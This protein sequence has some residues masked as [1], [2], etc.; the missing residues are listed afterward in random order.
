MATIVFLLTTACTKKEA[1]APVKNSIETIKEGL[2]A[3][4]VIF[5]GDRS[6]LLSDSGPDGSKSFGRPEKIDLS[7]SYSVP[8]ISGQ[9]TYKD[10]HLALLEVGQPNSPGSFVTYRLVYRALTGTSKWKQQTAT[11]NNQWIILSQLD[12]GTDYEVRVAKACS[13]SGVTGYSS[14]LRISMRP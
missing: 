14:S 4:L 6:Y 9:K 1:V 12:P 10:L 8:R 3:G 13:P 7:G 11:S 5:N 2:P